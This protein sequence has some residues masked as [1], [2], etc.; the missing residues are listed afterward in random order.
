MPTLDEI[1]TRFS[2]DRFATEAAQIEIA[3]AQPGYAKVQMPLTPLHRNMRGAPMGGAI[4]TLA[5]FAAA[6]AA[7]GHAVDT[8]TISLH[9]DI[10]FLS[11]AKGT[12]L[13]AEAKCIKQ[14]RSTSLFE[15]DVRDDLGTQVAHACVNGFVLRKTE[16]KAE[17]T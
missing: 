1:R 15:V 12:C 14:G 17:N 10:T 8:D 6:V 3:E 5:D 11:A 4:F 13:I 2:R 16:Q 7:N 9:A